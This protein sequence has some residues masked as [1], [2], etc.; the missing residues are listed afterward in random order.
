M[1]YE[2]RRMQ[3][4]GSPALSQKPSELASFAGSDA[5]NTSAATNRAKVKL[6][7][8]Q[9]QPAE[10]GSPNGSAISGYPEE[11][12]GWTAESIEFTGFAAILLACFFLMIRMLID[13]ALVRRPLLIPNLTIGGLIFIGL[14]L[15]MFLM[16]NVITSSPQNSDPSMPRGPGYSLL[17]VLPDLPTNPVNES[18]SNQTTPEAGQGTWL[19]NISRILAIVSNLLIVVGIVGIGYWHFD[20]VK[21]GIGCAVIY[22]LLPYAAQMTGSLEHIVPAALLCLAM[23]AYR[24]P[25]IAGLLLGSAAGLV[26][27]PLFLLPL[28][29][30]FY[31]HQGLGRFL[32]GSV[33]SLLILAGMLLLDG[34]NF[35]EQIS[36]MFGLWLPLTEGLEG[37]WATGRVPAAFRLPVLV[38]CIILSGSFVFWPPRKNLGSLMC[39]T[40]AIMLAVQFWHGFGGGL[41]MAWFLPFTLL[42]MFRPNLDDRIAANVVRRTRK[43]KPKAIPAT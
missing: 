14:A 18:D 6:V 23:L 3:A 15:F 32:A 5:A 25:L 42:T 8:M 43:N 20:N 37:V 39:G 26:Y 34:G 24:Q 40:A 13:P 28:W 21:T 38:A 11:P 22:L 10:S 2:G 9:D 30:S 31:W 4:S 33:T 17:N 1:V 27:Y 7:H 19:P 16:A 29:I 41:F 12:Q 35:G 36:Q